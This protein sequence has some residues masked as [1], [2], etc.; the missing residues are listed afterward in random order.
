MPKPQI[1]SRTTIKDWDGYMAGPLSLTQFRDLMQEMLE[2]ANQELKKQSDTYRTEAAIGGDY[3]RYGYIHIISVILETEAEA[4][5][6]L[7]GEN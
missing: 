2:A 3:D 4:G 6:R 7:K 1:K 5:T